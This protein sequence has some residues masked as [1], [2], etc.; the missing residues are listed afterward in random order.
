M[1][2][3]PDPVDGAIGNRIVEGRSSQPEAAPARAWQSVR[4]AMRIAGR[5]QPKSAGTRFLL[6]TL[7]GLVLFGLALRVDRGRRGLPYLHHWDEPFLIHRA[8]VMIESGNPNPRFF[9]YG[10]L[11]IY[12]DAVAAKVAAFRTGRLPAG[13]PERLGPDSPVRF[14]GALEDPLRR[15]AGELPPWWTS[16]PSFFR[17]GRT[18]SA[19]YGGLAIV[20]VAALA[21]R[22]GGDLAALCATMLIVFDRT[23]IRYTS[24][25]TVDAL[26][27]TTALA[28]LWATHRFLDGRRKV[29][30][31]A[32]F[33]AVGLTASTKYNIAIVGVVPMTATLLAT[34]GARPR[35]SRRWL[36]GG[37][38]LSAAT[39]VLTM[40]FAL[41]DHATFLRDLARVRRVYLEREP[42]SLFFIEPGWRHLFSDLGELWVHLGPSI[43]ALALAGLALLAVKRRSGWLLAPALLLLALNAL[44]RVPFHRN[45]LLLYPLAAVAAGVAAAHLA[46]LLAGRGPRLPLSLA[47]RAGAAVA[48]FAFAAGTLALASAAL[49]RGRQAVRTPPRSQ[50]MVA[51]GQRDIV[52]GPIA[53]AR[54]LALHPIDRAK[55]SGRLIERPLADIVCEPGDEVAALVPTATVAHLPK[56]AAK[57]ERLDRLL[58]VAGPVLWRRG[59]QPLAL[60]LPSAFAGV[61]LRL[62]APPPLDSG[63]CVPQAGAAVS[64]AS[65]IP[66]RDAANDGD[67]VPV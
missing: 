33:L 41:L 18:L 15:D 51:L 43:A 37:P 8:I 22:L 26:A 25:A 14:R 54:E 46:V 45:L 2:E 10:S 20:L 19:L 11:P 40:P 42:G 30:L 32:A 23:H 44:T 53:V 56:M 31:A 6:I 29:D 21:R 57:A 17:A 3:P 27:A 9:N 63:L 65:H 55:W 35:L 36:F 50:A 39:F 38:A 61:E 47:P 7:A 58:A 12:L 67:R 52:A 13:H 60:D 4:T 66:S 62:S 59:R 1:T 49:E 48:A 34:V 24:L 64:P 5:A 16:H 28:A